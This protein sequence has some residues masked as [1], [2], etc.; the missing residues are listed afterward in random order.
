VVTGNNDLLYSFSNSIG[1]N[2]IGIAA[3]YLLSPF[4]VIYLL[5]PVSELPTAFFLITILKIG[6]VGLTMFIF[7]N[8]KVK[9]AK[10]LIFSTS[11]ALMIYLTMFY[12]HTM[13]LDGVILLP[14]IAMG[15]DRMLLYSKPKLY[16]VTLFLAVVSNYYIGWMLCIFSAL[17]FVYRYMLIYKTKTDI[18]KHLAYLK[19]FILCSLAAVAVAAAV[20]IPAYTALQDTYRVVEDA[21]IASWKWADD[22]SVLD[23]TL[24]FFGTFTKSA[25]SV[26]VYNTPYIFCGIAIPILLAAFF[27]SR[28]IGK[29]EKVL[30][31]IFLGI[32][33]LGFFVPVF[34]YI[35]HGFSHPNGFYY[36]YS[37]LF[38]F[39]ALFLSYRAFL[40]IKKSYLG[41]MVFV[42]FIQILSLFIYD[43][44]N[45]K[46][47]IEKEIDITSQAGYKLNTAALNELLDSM[48]KTA[49]F[50]RAEM[51]KPYLQGNDALLFGYNGVSAHNSNIESNLARFMERLRLYRDQIRVVYSKDT[52]MAMDSL[53]GVKYVLALNDKRDALMSIRNDLALPVG[54]MVNNIAELPETDY[55]DTVNTMFR[56]LSGANAEI[57]TELIPESVKFENLSIEQKQDVTTYTAT[58]GS[59][60]GYIIFDLPPNEQD[61]FYMY[62]E[63]VDMA[64]TASDYLSVPSIFIDGVFVGPPEINRPIALT[65]KYVPNDTPHRLLIQIKNPLSTNHMKIYRESR[66]AVAEH[67]AALADE[68][69]D[70]NKISSSH[71]TCTVE[72]KEN[73]SLFFTIPNDEGW[74]VRVDGEKVKTETAFDVFMT[75][76]LTAG[77][78][79][80]EMKF[81]PRGLRLGG[82]VS[83]VALAA[84]SFVAYRQFRKNT[85]VILSS[86]LTAKR[87]RIRKAKLKR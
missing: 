38:V 13:W 6:C 12:Y 85:V 70:L 4:N 46:F 69:C 48:E 19:S 50:Y 25:S 64:Y 24:P 66:S 45:L 54:F 72:A 33:A 84:G 42:A 26:H 59:E 9:S 61:V 87:L 10:A 75:V 7:L 47:V 20:L 44:H 29:R 60:F 18:K 49:S 1:G 74:T 39:L 37:F 83:L 3:Y 16:V 23:K 5:F 41:F 63:D 86:T 81:V 40:L 32:L 73:G 22:Y 8:S 14:L 55:F 80:I 52:P 78:H 57:F 31:G 79:R 30:S 71:L 11:F 34:D 21:N 82:A 53:L 62:L 76:P 17:Y 65:S 68:P 35:W 43:T 28:K 67:Y 15:I 51:D 56:T 58:D 36:R 27:V 2:F 77:T